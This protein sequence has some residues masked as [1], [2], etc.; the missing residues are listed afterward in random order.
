MG[1]NPPDG[2]IIDYALAAPAGRV[3]L[4]FYDASGR[5]VR[6]YA[7]DDVAPPPIPH[8]DKP[9]YW[10]RPFV[11]PST[12]AGMHRFVWDLREPPPHAT[13]QDLPISAIPYDTPR[14]PE[15][16]LVVPGRYLVRLDVDGRISE[17]TFAVEIDPRVAVS[18]RALQ[19]QYRLARRLALLMD[20][21]YAAA[22]AARARSRKEA[23]AAY[24]ALN[25][26]CASLLDTIDGADAPP[27]Q[28][29]IAAVA[30]LEARAARLR[31]EN[32]LL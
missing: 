8:L 10:E 30:E 22:A 15:G 3:A 27:T 25:D 11:T 16:P 26:A 7:S 19:T 31:A 1:S 9:A 5:L 2:A 13:T 32:R 17:H 28:Q 20:A 29:A 21:S 23:A 12:T 4:S 14:V 6:R 18:Q 24:D